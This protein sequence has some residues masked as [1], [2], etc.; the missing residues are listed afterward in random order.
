MSFHIRLENGVVQPQPIA[1]NEGFIGVSTGLLTTSTVGDFWQWAYSDVVDNTSR[2]VLAEY[3]VAK[4][5]E[6]DAPTRTPWDA[7]DLLTPSGIKVQVKSSSYLQA[8]YQERPSNISFGIRKTLKWLP[9]SNE[10][11][12]PSRRY[13]DVYV[14]CLITQLDKQLL[15]PLD[16]AQWEFFI[17]KTS[18][19]NTIFGERKSI[20]LRQVRAISASYTVEDLGT[21]IKWLV[22][23]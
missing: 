13:S 6:A 8:W 10:L 11:A 15:N 21:G 12:G 22:E 17:A 5:I 19:I 1:P 14:F 2:G 18:Y 9:E 7:Y 4:A 3:I 23:T 20:T 16:L